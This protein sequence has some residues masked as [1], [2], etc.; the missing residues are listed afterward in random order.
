[1]QTIN[2]NGNLI[3]Y[4]LHC[5]NF[6]ETSKEVFARLLTLMGFKSNESMLLMM[7]RCSRASTRS[8]EI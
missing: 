3:I 2:S 4:L 5:Q 7:R 6:R 1:M 8:T